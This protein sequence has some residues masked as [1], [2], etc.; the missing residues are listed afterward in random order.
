M[1]GTSPVD[2]PGTLLTPPI[3]APGLTVEHQRDRLIVRATQR[4]KDAV[5]GTLRFPY[6]AQGGRI[7]VV[8]RR[9][10]AAEG[11]THGDLRVM[12][13][14]SARLSLARRLGLPILLA[15][16]EPHGRQLMLDWEALD[17][18]IAAARALISRWPRVRERE[19]HR[20]PVERAVGLEDLPATERLLAGG[21]LPSTRSPTGALIAAEALYIARQERPW[22]SARVSAASGLLLEQLDRALA[23]LDPEYTSA[24]RPVLA[25]LREVTR[26]AADPRRRHELQPS[27]WPPPARRFYAA[28][29]IATTSPEGHRGRGARWA[30]ACRVWQVYEDWVYERLA[31]ILRRVLGKPT[32]QRGP[33]LTWRPDATTTIVLRHQPMFSW[34]QPIRLAGE[35]W[36]AVVGSGLQPDSVLVLRK[37]DGAAQVLAIDAKDRRA[38]DAAIVASEGSKY[39]WG[40]RRVATPDTPA[41]DGVVLV[42][43]EGGEEGP[44][45]RDLGRIRCV[46][47][48]PFSHI[49]RGQDRLDATTVRNWITDLGMPL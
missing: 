29:R 5:A 27:S 46:A 16:R 11:W 18:C 23:E 49:G 47:A 43:P 42:A 26:T 45:P 36:C 39:L 13:E 1:I 8:R 32:Q 33:H 35:A 9:L 30:P 38:L 44:A 19:H 25:P 34:H 6:V 12:W 15:D 31:H 17:A 21:G 2:V 7:R 40:L 14:A 24:A 48:A 28:A 3:T 41:L 22:R 10:P 37:D 20:A 4:G